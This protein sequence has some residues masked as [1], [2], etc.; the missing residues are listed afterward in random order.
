MCNEKVDLFI[1]ES[2]Q[3]VSNHLK[4]ILKLKFV[5]RSEIQFKEVLS[6][7]KSEGFYIILQSVSYKALLICDSSFCQHILERANDIED[8]RTY[9]EL[10]NKTEPLALNVKA[11]LANLSN[12]PFKI[13]RIEV[14]SNFLNI[15]SPSQAIQ[16]YEFNTHLGSLSGKLY[17]ALQSLV[18]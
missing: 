4:R 18:G 3:S 13:E 11:F 5:K 6:S 8:S 7:I 9:Q 12:E 1:Q 10:I 17:I 2:N 16:K 14:H 15:M